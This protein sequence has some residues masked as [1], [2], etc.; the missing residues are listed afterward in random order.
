[1]NGIVFM[2]GK[3]LPADQAKISIFDRAVMFADAIYEVAGVL[4]GKLVDFDHH[5]ERYFASVGKV[6]IS[7]PLSKLEILN[8]F[9]SLI[10]KNGISEGMVYMQVT[11]G[12]AERDFIWK[13]DLRPNIFMFATP[14]AAV[15]T[16]AAAMGVSLF[17]TPD[18]RWARRDIKSVNLLAQV[19]AKN[20]AHDAG[21][22]EALMIDQNGFVTECGSTSFFIVKGGAV[23]TRPLNNDILPGVTRRALVSLCSTKG[24]E[25]EERSF[26]LIEAIK[27]DEAF[28]TGASSNVIPVVKIDE[29]QIGMGQPG[30]WTRE[31]QQIYLIY[32][33]ESLI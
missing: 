28:I 8:A 33:R 9:R 20:T 10:E 26:S 14:K 7:S 19:L 5:M 23:I 13:E 15:D 18:L 22:Y 1:M 31:L 27:A 25:L 2:N 32:A 11:R 4:D 12:E 6:S 30:K 21:A 3:Y 24:I 16:E 29:Q 17:S